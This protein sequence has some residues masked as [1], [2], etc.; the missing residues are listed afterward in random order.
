MYTVWRLRGD[1]YCF[2]SFIYYVVPSMLS[3]LYGALSY[4]VKLMHSCRHD[5]SLKAQEILM[6]I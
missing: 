3:E 1:L 4:A 6:G 2:I 5:C